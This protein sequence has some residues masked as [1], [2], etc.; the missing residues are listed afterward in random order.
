MPEWAARIGWQSVAESGVADNDQDIFGE[1]LGELYYGNLWVNAAVVFISIFAT[2]IFTSLGGGLGWVIII[3]ASVGTYF[4]Y[5]MKRFYR[6]ARSD[7]SRELVRE[8]LED[9]I[10]GESAEWLNEF[11]RRFWLIYEPVLSSTIVGIA[12]GI[13]AGSTP[14][15]L[16]SI[17]LTTFTLGTKPAVIESIKSYPKTEDDIVVMDWKL[18]FNPNDLANMTRA[19]LKNKI[20]SKIVLT[21]RV[22]RG[23]VGA[24]IPVLLEDLSLYGI[25]QVKLKLVN[26]F[27]HIK[28]ASISFLEEPKLDYVLKPIGGE[29]LGFDIS[30]IPG[31]HSFIQDQVHATLRPM[32]YAPNVFSLDLESIIGG[33]PIESALGVLKLKIMSAKGLRNVETFGASDPYVKVTLHGN[34]LLAKTKTI[35]DSLN[36]VWDETCFLIL[37][38]LNEDL[39]LEIYDYN[40]M[41]KHKPLGTAKFSLATLEDN[42]K[43]EDV[44]LSVI[45]EGKPRGE[46]KIGTTWYPVVEA[47]EHD[48]APESNTGVLRFTIHQAK[49]LDPRL[50]IVGQYN[51]YAELGLNGK[52]VNT[53]RTVKRSNNPNWEESFEMFITNKAGAELFVKVRDARDLAADPVVGSWSSKL[54]SFIDVLTS[55]KNDW[56][57]V[58]DAASGKMRLSCTWKPVLFDSEFEHGGYEDAIGMIRIH[59]KKA[60]DLKR[61]Q[62]MGRSIDPYV[63]IRLSATYRGRTEVVLDTQNPKWLHEVHYIPVHSLKESINLQIFSH[64]SKDFGSV[65]FYVNKLAR[66][67]EDGTYQATESFDSY[68]PLMIADDHKGSL[69]YSAS[70]YPTLQTKK[71]KSPTEKDTEKVTEQTSEKDAEKVSEKGEKKDEVDKINGVE[72]I[73]VLDY[74]CGILVVNIKEATIDRKDVSVD[75]YIDNGLYPVFSTNRCKTANPDWNQVTDVFIK[76]LDFAKLSFH[77]KQSDHKTPIGVCVRDVRNLLERLDTDSISLDIEGLNDSKLIIGVRYI[78]MIYKVE[79]SESINNM[80]TLRVTVKD[81]GDLPAADSSGTSDPF[82]VI[83]IN[84]EKVHKTKAV[85]KTLNPTFENEEF[86]INVLSR[87]S[88]EF[89]IEI[90]DWNKIESSTKLGVGKLDLSDLPTF[91]K[92]NRRV[93]LCDSKTNKPAGFVNLSLLFSPKLL[94]KKRL[95]TGTIAGATRTLTNI[96]TGIGGTVVAGGDSFLRTGAGFVSS[97]ASAVGSGFGLLKRKDKDDKLKNDESPTKEN[98]TFLS[99]SSAENG[100]REIRPSTYSASETTGEPGILTLHLIEA[101]DLIAN[102]RGGTSDPYVRVRI[103]KKEIYK[104]QHIKKTLTPRWDDSV[105]IPNPSG[106]PL[107]IDLSVRDFNTIGK[108]VTIGEYHLNLWEHI[109]PDNYTKDCWVDLIDG[110]DGKLHIKLEYTPKNFNGDSGR[111]SSEENHSDSS[112]RGLNLSLRRNKKE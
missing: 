31:L 55:T 19:Q 59:I 42:P 47:T 11:L 111:H 27:P 48:P 53:T 104:T 21:I 112:R 3:C 15:F 9:V 94:P 93:Q 28:T 4:K 70:F 60:E 68:S 33:I 101:K 30:H 86:T 20:N 18:S 8:K 79:L 25:I 91:E 49:D 77:I 71:V 46:I 52:V 40:E 80:G 32:M 43:Q 96:G 36:P 69:F 41:T 34:K 39:N 24:G 58:N 98:E 82:A 37:T 90:F 102:D 56:F 6:N 81:A 73:N 103:N 108:D 17:R 95:T 22:G 12:D 50:S 5:S 62:I 51:P 89:I 66:Q 23:M 75:L 54:Q 10:T 87:T 97:G 16:D 7:I 92:A 57:N 83:S 1:Y 26:T 14:Q 38:S 65:E 74:D 44:T 76:E 72:D 45:Y 2:W 78:P 105:Q 106:A 67:N 84:G 88:D 109:Q 100:T 29:M 110:K 99:P 35:Y 63:L 64:E 61:P 13:L 85:K 107:M